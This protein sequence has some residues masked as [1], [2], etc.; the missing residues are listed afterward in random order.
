MSQILVAG[1]LHWDV[2]VTAPRLPQP[3]E[4]VVGQEVRYLFGG[5]GG[6][7]AVAAAQMGAQ[8]AMAGCVGDD[9]FAAKLLDKLD[10]AGIDRTQVAAVPRA[11]GMSVAIVD[12]HGSY[13]A[14]IVSAANL[15]VDA[16]TITVP[17]NSKMLLLQNEIPEQANLTLAYQ[18]R[19]H[20]AT[21]VLNAAPTRAIAPQLLQLTDIL[22]TNRLE[23][24]QLLNVPEH[25]LDVQ[26]ALPKLATLG[27]A[28]V[29][30]TLSQDGLALL[31]QGQVQ[32]RPAHRVEVISTHGA[33]DAFIG[34]LAA[35]MTSDE[36]LTAAVDF[37]QAAAALYIS[38]DTKQR[39]QLNAD[40]IGAF[41]S[42]VSCTTA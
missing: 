27:P 9:A 13:G 39:A 28:T 29:I 4:T 25:E 22:V 24:A 30:V 15:A 31:H 18:A 26:V 40:R 7:Q 17:A 19:K 35:Q 12:Q 32:R 5:K 10:Q 11:S 2:V 16:T 3:D 41:L 21:V 33:G 38:T 20:G 36:P 6:N 23:A 42:Q 1:A 14:V 8:V 37:A 34:A